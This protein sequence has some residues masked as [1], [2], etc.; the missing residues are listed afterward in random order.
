MIEAR[1]RVGGK[2]FTSDVGGC[3]VDLG[4]H[5]VGPAQRRLL[6]LARELGIDVEKQ[7][8]D[9]KHLLA[10]GGE[11]R[12]YT[13]NI[14]LLSIRASLEMGGAVARAELRRLLVNRDSPWR[15]RGARRLD[16]F[17]L[18]HHMRGLR[19]DGARG[20]RQE[21]DAVLG[22]VQRAAGARHR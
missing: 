1:D 3:A 12:S 16:S 20:L 15:S 9:G 2:M 8:L 14:P 4:A 22:P 19:T 21:A 7:Y 17:T 5:W 18:A 13:G 11:H 6:G 10:I